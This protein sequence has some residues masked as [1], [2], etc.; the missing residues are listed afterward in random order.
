[1]IDCRGRWLASIAVGAA[2]VLTGCGGDTRSQTVVTPTTQP[3]PTAPSVVGSVATTTTPPAT[4]PPTAVERPGP[5]AATTCSATGDASHAASDGNVSVTV[6]SLRPAATFLA[7][8]RTTTGPTTQA[9]TTDERGKGTV[10][11]AVGRTPAGER[12]Q[13]DVSVA[14]GAETCSTTATAG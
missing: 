7:T 14:G 8:A 4:P 12:V 10:P 3:T 9:G 13:I 5:P 1:V 2:G 11:I 6:Q